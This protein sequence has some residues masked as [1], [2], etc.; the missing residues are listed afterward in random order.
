M[1]ATDLDR[2]LELVVKAL[3]FP[4]LHL[5]AMIA[6]SLGRVPAHEAIDP[7]SKPPGFSQDVADPIARAVV[8]ALA[9]ALPRAVKREP[10]WTYQLMLD[11]MVEVMVHVMVYVMGDVGRIER[12]SGGLCRPDDEVGVG[13][14][15]VAFLTAGLR[16]G[17]LPPSTVKSGQR[18][19][20][21]NDETGDL[22]K[23]RR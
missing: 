14:Q 17:A 16:H 7:N 5:R 22:S 9:W 15:M 1:S 12:L 3:V 21:S 20:G 18:Q 11:A 8:D 10:W 13:R 6:T 4:K 19:G 23:R 2:R